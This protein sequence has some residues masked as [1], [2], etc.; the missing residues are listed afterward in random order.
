MRRPDRPSGAGVRFDD[1]QP[2]TVVLVRHG[3]TAMTVSHGY[4]GSGVPGPG[5]DE[6]GRRQARDAAALV[7]RIGR[8]LWGD[9]EF[10]GLVVASPMVRTQETGRIVADRLGLP[11]E[12]DAAFQEA[13]FGDWQGLTDHEIERRWP[14]LLVPW[15]TTGRVRPP[16][17]GGESVADVGDRV[18]AG[19]D[20]L[21][22]LG[23]PRTVVV[24]SHAV[25]IRAMVGVGMGAQPGSWSQLRVAPGS[26]SILRLFSDRRDEIAVVGVPSTGWFA[27][28]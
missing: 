2:V 27:A 1:E 11:L 7:E 4:S 13:N 9:V 3:Q 12:T 22:A 8:D 6:T 10:P 28:P 17:P 26:V 16:G 5:L 18:R 23:G 24:V 21:Q 19:L 25:A 14:G 15:H 20:R